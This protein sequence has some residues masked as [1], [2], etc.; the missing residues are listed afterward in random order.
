MN[1][2]IDG[3]KKKLEQRIKD[4]PTKLKE[5]KALVSKLESNVATYKLEKM[6][7]D[8]HI[9][10]M[11]DVVTDLGKGL[12]EAREENKALESEIEDLEKIIELK[13]DCIEELKTQ[14]IDLMTE[15]VKERERKQA[16]KEDSKQMLKANRELREILKGKDEIL[17]TTK[18]Y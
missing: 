14:N 4:D 11:E 2:E 8:K 17:Q 12:Q 3:L 18:N 10:R 15:L 9:T 6:F 5:L 1:K 7:A 13:T 16:Y